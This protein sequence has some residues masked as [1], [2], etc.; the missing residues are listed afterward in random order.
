[1]ALS[2]HLPKR[3]TSQVCELC[4][5]DGRLGELSDEKLTRVAEQYINGR[6]YP[7]V[8]KATE[9]PRSHWVGLI[10]TVILKDHGI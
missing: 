1:M 8:P 4:K 2:T 5:I 7:V 3:L 9:L 10:Q 6:Y